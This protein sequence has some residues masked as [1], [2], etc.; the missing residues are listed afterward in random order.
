MAWRDR[1]AM[2]AA[3]ACCAVR[4]IGN[5]FVH[6]LEARVTHA[7]QGA[8]DAVI[9]VDLDGLIAPAGTELRQDLLANS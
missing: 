9:A 5:A 8:G 1:L 3:Q 4:V 6:R 2:S 7:E